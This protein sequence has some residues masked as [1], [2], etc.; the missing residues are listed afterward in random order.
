MAQG[1]AILTLDP[2]L[3]HTESPSIA[4]VGVQW[5]DLNSLRLPENQP[6]S[7]NF[8]YGFHHCIIKNIQILPTQLS[9][10][11]TGFAQSCKIQFKYLLS[12]RI[13]RKKN[14]LINKESRFNSFQASL[15]LSPNHRRQRQENHLN[16]GS[17][18]CSELRSYHCTPA[19][20]TESQ[21]KKT[22]APKSCLPLSPGRGWRLLTAHAGC[23]LGSEQKKMK[24]I[25]SMFCRWFLVF[26]SVVVVVVLRGS[27]AL[28]PWL[29]C[30]GTI[31]AYCNLHLLDSSNSPV[32][33][34]GVD[35]IT[36]ICHHVWLIF[37]FL[38]K[39]GFHHV[40]QAGLELLTSSDLPALASPSARIIDRVLL[41]HPG[42]SAVVRSWLNATS[43]FLVQEILLPQ[44]PNYKSE[45]QKN[46]VSAH[47]PSNYPASIW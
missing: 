31:S 14:K 40:G 12:V 45:W 3:K 39:I 21:K 27:L 24:K 33:A 34:C 43:T 20:A 41:C 28:L 9:N 32:S 16:L 35:G 19:W 46:L 10:N 22:K 18:G 25:I 15:C 5:H 30:S 6:D 17:G 1:C 47:P 7:V 26:F 8:K 29:E 23:Q 13:M 11:Q 2:K 4:Q 36:G 38:V 44:L 42:W 37:V